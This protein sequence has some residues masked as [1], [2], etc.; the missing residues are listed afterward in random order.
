[1]MIVVTMAQLFKY[2]WRTRSV[3]VYLDG[4]GKSGVIKGPN[5]CCRARGFFLV[6]AEPELW[7][8]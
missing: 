2:K 8:L 5:L 6:R 3:T 7:A 1:M 4:D